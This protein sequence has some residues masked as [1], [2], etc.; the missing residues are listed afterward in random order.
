V[1]MVHGFLGLTGYYCKFIQPYG[2][3]DIVASLTQ[4]IKKEGFS[5]TPAA[6]F[7][8]LKTTLTNVSVL[9]LLDFTM[10]FTLD[11]NASSSIF[12]TVLH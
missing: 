2:V 7:D 9:Y 8:A 10:P 12:G 5:W 11:C 1:R 3:G 6:A 4:L